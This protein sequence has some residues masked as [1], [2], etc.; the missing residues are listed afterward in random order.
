MPLSQKL[1][2]KKMRKSQNFETKKHT[3]NNPQVI[4]KITMEMEIYFEEMIMKM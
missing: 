2:N 4:E 3:S 1:N